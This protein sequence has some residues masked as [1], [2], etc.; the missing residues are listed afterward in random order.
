MKVYEVI[1]RTKIVNYRHTG[2][3]KRSGVKGI[4]IHFTFIVM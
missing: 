4:D 2:V 1:Q 3:L